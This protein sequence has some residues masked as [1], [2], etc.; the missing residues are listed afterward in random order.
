L[1][2]HRVTV[3]KLTILL[4]GVVFLAYTAYVR[5]L[6]SRDFIPAIIGLVLILIGIISFFIG[7][8]EE[9]YVEETDLERQS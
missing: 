3:V 8:E 1:A 6:G 2:L 5:N 4:I 9:R 7:G